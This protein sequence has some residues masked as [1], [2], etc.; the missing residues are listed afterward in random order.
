MAHSIDEIAAE[1]KPGTGMT[2]QVGSDSY[3]WWVTEVLA[4]KT[5]GLC[6][7]DARFDEAHPWE[8]GVQAVK[9][10]DPEAGLKATTWIRHERGEWVEVTRDGARV[11]D[12]PGIVTFGKAFSYL[13]PSF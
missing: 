9:P 3:P 1:L 4:G 12:F 5:I 13:D 10:Y 8:G 2:Q 6:H 11:Q 7:A